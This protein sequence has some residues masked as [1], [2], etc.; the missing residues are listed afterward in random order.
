NS[1]VVLTFNEAIDISTVNY[2][3]VPI[4]ASG[5]S[6]VLSGNYALDSS[7]KVLTFTP[8][9]PMPSNATITIQF[10]N[11]GIADLSGNHSCSFSGAFVTGSGSDTTQPQVASI[12]PNNAATGIAP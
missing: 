3:T 4:S 8:L 12:T 1:S 2:G 9:T 11:G 7:G 5:F 6:G 10:V